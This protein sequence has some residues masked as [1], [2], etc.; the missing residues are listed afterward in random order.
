MNHGTDI[1]TTV[2]IYISIN[3]SNNLNIGHVLNNPKII[4]TLIIIIPSHAINSIQKQ[5]TATKKS[6]IHPLPT[7][8]N[9]TAVQ[10]NDRNT[11]LYTQ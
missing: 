9:L 1:K 11:N 4:R 8:T 6:L 5:I 2:P 3:S 10:N 7:E